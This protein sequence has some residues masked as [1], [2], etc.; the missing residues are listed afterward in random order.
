MGAVSVVG[1]FRTIKSQRLFAARLI[2][3][4]RLF[5][6]RLLDRDTSDVFSCCFFL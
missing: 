4:Q 1:L 3:S 2:K 5:A 6:A